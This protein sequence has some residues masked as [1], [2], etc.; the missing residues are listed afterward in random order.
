MGR[1]HTMYMSDVTWDQLQ[2]LKKDDQ[3]MSEA[4]RIAIAICYDNQD[5]FDLLKLKDDTIRA[6]ENWRRYIHDNV[7]RKCKECVL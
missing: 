3:S 1:Q 2:S 5:S 4:I 6:H 7:C